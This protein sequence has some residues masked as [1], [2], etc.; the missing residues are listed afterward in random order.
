[1]LS[2]IAE[3]LY[4]IGRYVER[5]EGTARILDVHVH[6]L[7]EGPA[8][9]EPAA[10]QLLLKIM[11]AP[12][13]TAPVDVDARGVT[14]L[15]A[16]DPSY[17][18]SIVATLQAARTNARGVSE[19]ISFEIWEA[20]NA[21]FNSLPAQIGV[22]RQVGPYAFFRYVRERAALIAGIIDL[23]IIRDDVWCF[24]ALGR[25]LERVDMMARLLTAGLSEATSDAEWVVLLRSCGAYEAFLRVYA[26]EPTASLA[27]EFLMLDRLLPRSIVRSLTIAEECL[28]ALDPDSGRVGTND[29]ARRLLA[30][31]RSGL[32]YR[33][34]SELFEDLLGELDAVQEACRRASVALAAR[35]FR[36]ADII[37]WSREQGASPLVP[38]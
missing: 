26:V 31:V 19:A 16:F 17:P 27:A 21:T 1:V 29:E 37:A 7:L 4:W 12:A 11:G 28:S 32:E 23:A 13:E 15:L 24:L 14:E 36:R 2:R 25:S 6:Y 30:L 22:G 35:Y 10:C 18:N 8:A 20:I 9:D 3:S 33:R 5:A 38:S 34:I